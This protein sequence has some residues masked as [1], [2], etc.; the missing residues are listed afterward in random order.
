M[1]CRPAR[2]ACRKI[3]RKIPVTWLDGGNRKPWH[4]TDA[5]VMQD[6]LIKSQKRLLKTSLFS[7]DSADDSV[8]RPGSKTDAKLSQRK[9]PTGKN[10]PWLGKPS[11]GHASDFT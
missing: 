5:E 9:V 4:G 10:H 8:P 1:S 2:A 6:Y 3:S 11:L 7:A